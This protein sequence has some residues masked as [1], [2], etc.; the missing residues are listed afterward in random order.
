MDNE[1]RKD[2]LQALR[3]VQPALI[4]GNIKKIKLVS[5]MTLH[6]AGISQ[7]QD[8][9]GISVIIYTL[10]KIYNRPR[11]YQQPC[12][13]KF[14]DQMIKELQEAQNFLHK[15]DVKNYRRKIKRIFQVI[16]MFEKKFGMYMREA[17][18]QSKIKRGGRIV[19][20]G[21]SMGR[22][23]QLLGI[24]RWELMGYI[25]GTKL[26]DVKHEGG[27]TVDKRLGLMRKV[28]SL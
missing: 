23:A 4:S 11:L 20:H 12:F 1:V 15:N 6:N 25:G 16:A 28:F 8:S 7:D 22:A 14:K 24:S 9:V 2:I 18:V 10:S 26:G 19:E 21:I 27:D 13:L 5:N 17:I 3:K